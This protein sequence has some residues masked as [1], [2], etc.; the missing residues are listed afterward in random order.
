MTCSD[1]RDDV[2]GFLGGLGVHKFYLGQIGWGIAYLVFFWTGIPALIGF[3]EGI[4]YLVQ[5][6]DAFHARYNSLPS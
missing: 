1:Q 2:I 3:V 4:W 6:D 5:S